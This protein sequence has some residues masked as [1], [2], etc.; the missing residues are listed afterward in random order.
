MTSAQARVYQA[1]VR[2]YRTHD[3]GPSLEALR[4]LLGVQSLGPLSIH[5]RALIA[6]GKLRREGL[7]GPL[8][9]VVTESVCPCC[10]QVVKN[11]SGDG[12]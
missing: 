8:Q 11:R 3:V 7:R 9:V 12:R 6:E 5:I 1:I 10:G 4:D 2:W